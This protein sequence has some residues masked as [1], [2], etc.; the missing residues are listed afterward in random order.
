MRPL[1]GL[2]LIA[3]AGLLFGSA[4]KAQCALPYTFT[5]G[6]TA[7]ATQVMANFNALLSCL[8]PGGS[9]NA[10]QYNSG[11]GVLGGVGPL[12]DG[13]VVIGSTGNPPQAQTL[14]A[15]TGISIANVAGS[16]TL[17]ST[18]T[19]GLNGLY[20][21]VMS[22]TPTSTSTGLTNWL[23]QSAATVSDSPTGL[24]ITAPISAGTAVMARYGT[25]PSPPYK[26]N[27]LVAA[28]RSSTY[29]NHVGIGWYNGSDK[30]QVID[31]ATYSGG[32]NYVEVTNWNSATSFSSTPFLTPVNAFSQPIWLQIADDGTNVSFGFSQDGANFLPV[33][34]A[35]KS[36]GW[37]GT[38]G[39]S[40]LVM[41]VM[42]LGAA[43]T[44]GTLMSWAQN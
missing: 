19:V 27:V 24:A 10:I 33:F 44:V 16:I 1:S 7:D 39:Y 22:A 17:S 23:N 4:A 14:T 20:R 32:A 12:T 37:L 11:G 35:A 26:I 38:T 25:A 30:L 2:G 40:N 9:T 18:G 3:A 8:T 6:Q 5:N 15:G 34:T 13:Q 43:K 21:Q 28:T 29:F 42:P 31:L 36:T 41:T